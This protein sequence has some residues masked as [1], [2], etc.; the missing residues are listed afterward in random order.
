VDDP[1]ER[2]RSGGTSTGLGLDIARRVAESA[3]GGLSVGRSDLGGA[4]VTLDVAA[5]EPDG[6]L[7]RGR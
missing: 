7:S 4:A 1:V 5:D 3:G 2:G 6:D